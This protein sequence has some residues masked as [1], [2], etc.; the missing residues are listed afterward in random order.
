MNAR[1]LDA[2]REAAP[3]GVDFDGLQVERNGGEYRFSTPRTEGEGL[4]EEQLRARADEAP[5][6]VSNWH[7]WRRE[8]GNPGSATYD[9]LRWLER[10]SERSVVERYEALAEGFARTWGQL[11]I[12][13]SLGTDG[14]RRYD[15]RHEDDAD[16]EVSA[17]EAHADPLDARE[18]VTY[19]D[20]GH[21]RPLKTAPS[22]PTGWVYPDL[23]WEELV[24]TVEFVYPATIANWHRERNGDL[25]VTHF[26]ECAERQTGIYDIIDGLSVES[27]EDA[28]EACCVDSQCLKRRMWDEDEETPLSI[29]RGDGEFPCRE[30]CSLFVTAARKFV[31]LDREDARPYEFELTPTEKEQLE[32]ILDAVAEG[33]VDEIREAD[34]N[35][36][37][38][39]YRARYLRAKRMDE[40]GLSGTPTYPEDHDDL[41]QERE[42]DGGR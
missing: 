8:V 16:R 3:G 31:T 28:A 27:L 39:R 6:F 33:R 14:H 4:T 13:A 11:R 2:L 30:P 22:L 7:F 10:G 9:F 25:D 15:L 42:A 37:A 24:R 36:G 1:Q 21:Y 26:R 18:L 40:R 23:D 5:W 29:E 34:L 32:E 20:R 12:T 41:A 17:L 19:D 35:K 38:N